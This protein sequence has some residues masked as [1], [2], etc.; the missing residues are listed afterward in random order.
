MGITYSFDLT[1]IQSVAQGTDANGNMFLNISG[2]GIL[3]ATGF[4]NTPGT[5]IF[6][7]NEAG[8]TFSFSSSNGAQGLLMVVLRSPSLALAWW[9][10]KHCVGNWLLARRRT[11]TNKTIS[12]QWER[13]RCPVFLPRPRLRTIPKFSQ[14]EFLSAC[15]IGDRAIASEKRA[16]RSGSP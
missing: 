8:G 11:F 4:D 3:H 12:G 15:N 10:S 9:R 13:S 6:T 14:V 5:Y 2:T 16:P 7:A 1:A